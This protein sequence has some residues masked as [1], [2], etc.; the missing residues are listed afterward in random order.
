MSADPDPFLKSRV[1]LARR[2]RLH[3]RLGEALIMGVAATLFLLYLALQSDSQGMELGACVSAGIGGLLIAILWMLETGQPAFDWACK[4]DRNLGL[5]GR[6]LAGLNAERG[7]E[8]SSIGQLLVEGLRPRVSRK[9]I[10]RKA[11]PVSRW[12]LIL[13]FMG[14]SL[15]LQ[16]VREQRA[17]VDRWSS[18]A[19][20]F[21]E[22]QGLLGEAQ[23]RAQATAGDE[24][25]LKDIRALQEAARRGA[26]EMEIGKGEAGEWGKKLASMA[27]ELDQLGQELHGDAAWDRTMDR[28]QGMVTALQDR[29]GD[30]RKDGL[31]SEALADS[32]SGEAPGNP[33]PGIPNRV[34][35]QGGDPSRSV[36]GASSLNSGEGGHAQGGPGGSSTASAVP[37]TGPETIPD[38]GE[39]G[40]RLLAIP[41][42]P[43]PYRSLARSFLAAALE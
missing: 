2:V 30:L 31:A 14:G 3:A 29:V 11:V 24:A 38:W 32:D 28:A 13:P 43:H 21:R 19:P 40:Q 12:I 5:N 25:L 20:Q 41:Q 33:V 22:L 35:V 27:S 26:L 10:L 6:L 39:P 7:A 36:P 9:A 37:N 4:V 17:Q 8:T 18:S 16:G 34:E 15:L 42:V 1:G 23:Q